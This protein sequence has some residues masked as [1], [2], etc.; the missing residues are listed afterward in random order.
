LRNRYKSRFV[1][2]PSIILISLVSVFYFIQILNNWKLVGLSG[3]QGRLYGDSYQ[4]IS[5]AG[6]DLEGIEKLFIFNPERPECYYTYGSLLL[7]LLHIL[8]ITTD[9]L[10][11][12]A[13]FSITLTL[14][15][16]FSQ[17]SKLKNM[18][19]SFYA[20][21]V[22]TSPGVWLLF[23]RGNFDW[24]IFGLV[25]FSGYL[26]KRES[27]IASAAVITISALL[28]FYTF[29][30]LIIPFLFAAN[31]KRF[32]IS[33]MA[34]SALP[35]CVMEA[36]RAGVGG[37]VYQLTATYGVNFMGMTLNAFGEMLNVSYKLSAPLSLLLG[38]SISVLLLLT[39][40]LR[41]LRYENLT[42]SIG[43]NTLT[44][45]IFLLL[46]CTYLF[47]YAAGSSYDYRLIFLVGLILRFVAL[48]Q[49]VKLDR[50]WAITGF[51]A[52]WLTYFYAGFDNYLIDILRLMGNI[53]QYLIFLALAKTVLNSLKL[54]IAREKNVNSNN[55]SS[56]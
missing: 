29:P 50:F 48:T 7:R 34:L 11:P 24:L 26:C 40:R 35:I 53:C 9:H 36:S 30:L 23:E 42:K 6:C 28:K 10:I 3:I 14:I 41:W 56:T 44:D 55:Y 20:L 4:V 22:L 52:V 1:T 31:K 32:L 15:L 21:A 38:L 33:I 5:A 46:S 13:I 37:L 27:Y 43:K 39:N 45:P 8:Q 51:L 47:S 2:L 19:R 16:C 54:K 18:K 17:V 25:V 49:S 12:V